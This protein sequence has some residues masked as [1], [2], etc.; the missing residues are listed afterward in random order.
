MCIGEYASAKDVPLASI[1][2]PTCKFDPNASVVVPGELGASAA[3]VVENDTPDRADDMAA[4]KPDDLPGDVPGNDAAGELADLPGDIPD[5][6]APK[7]KAKGKAKAVSSPNAKGKAKGKARGKAKSTASRSTAQPSPKAM[8]NATDKAKASTTPAPSASGAAPASASGEIVP[9]G[10]DAEPV[11]DATFDGMWDDKVFCSNCH[12]FSTFQKCRVLSKVA[13]TWRCNAC[14]TKCNQLRRIHGSWPTDQFLSLSKDV[15]HLTPMA[16]VFS[17]G[18]SAMKA[19]FSCRATV[20]L[21]DSQRLHRSVFLCFACQ[22]RCRLC[23]QR[24]S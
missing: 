9:V 22:R 17:C 4:E 23:T 7:A 16:F 20:S 8:A 13:G 18:G 24:L 19:R 12:Q 2:C 15:Q 6:A 5:S 14:S 10:S 11:A 1:R 21:L 3:D